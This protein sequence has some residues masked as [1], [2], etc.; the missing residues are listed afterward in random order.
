MFSNTGTGRRFFYGW[1][2]VAISFFTLLVVFGIRLS[3][4]VFFVALIEE[5]GWSRADTA[6]IFSASMITFALTSTPAGIALDR[7][8][9]RR[10]FGA[11]VLVLGAGLLLSG[12]IATLWQLVLAYGVVASLG[13]TI[14]GLGLQASLVSRWFQRKRGL[15]IGLA[16]AGTGI[17]SLMLTP[18]V[19]WVIAAWDWRLAYWC[20]AALAFLGFPFNALLLRLNP[21]DM[22]L[23]QDGAAPGPRDV[24]T[25]GLARD[26]TLG[27][28]VR[29]PA[30]WLLMLAGLLAIGP[31]RMLTV[32]Q[33]AA[34][35]DAGF[36]RSQAAAM[37]GLGGAVTAVSFILFG[38]L[39]DRIGR[40]R[41]Y[42]LGALCL[43]AAVAL[44][45]ALRGPQQAA[46]LWG[47]VLLFGLGEGSRAS[48]VTATAS[49]LFP[50][51]A[52]GAVNGA[53]G[54]MFGLGAAFFPWLAG[55]IFDSLG[56]YT[57][58]FQIAAG[59]ILISALALWIVNRRS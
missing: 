13:I 30:F 28:A 14:L 8:G 48:L 40:G 1:V 58:A 59:A 25:A 54:S 16:F 36:A 7:W 51:Q 10:V 18:G 45:N 49:D 33:L 9:A 21:A 39:S 31:V 22:A 44:L 55:W 12:M 24:E 53:V 32:H 42:M 34:I 41:A 37:V 27:A 20:L 23:L 35:T 47:Y 11:G 15:A 5:F 3:F 52:V 17:G 6:F 46:F 29:A 38:A 26:W 2:I 4:S 57:L 19:E 56:S 50:G 43:L